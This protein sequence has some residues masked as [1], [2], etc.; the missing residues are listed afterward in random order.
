MLTRHLIA[1]SILAV[2]AVLGSSTS[3]LAWGRNGHRAAAALTESRLTPAASA[4][5]KALLDPNE[6]LAAASTWA[7]E[8]RREY[9]EASLWHYVN[10]PI[11]EAKYDAKFCGEKGCVIQKIADFRKILADKSAPRVER[12][13]ALRFLAHFVQDMHQPVHVGDRNDRGGNDMQL[14]FFG[15]GSNMHR[16][17]DSGLLDKAYPDEA[18]L[19]R[20]ITALAAADAPKWA[21]G[22]VE[23]WANESL[24]AARKAYRD[25]VT[26]REL[27]KGVKLGDAYQAANAPVAVRRL[28]MS[29]VRLAT[30]LNA[31]FAE[32]P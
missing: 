30:I 21:G 2:A 1:A 3:A 31:I 20:A 5:V 28:A 17:W 32:T 12:Q 10:V 29:G 19:T 27:K 9:P 14:Q 6:S 7:D 25:P 24:D 26:D 15:E 11:T 8:V 16:L 23:D 18:A 4:A 13:K 22:T